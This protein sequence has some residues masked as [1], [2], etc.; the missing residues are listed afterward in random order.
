LFS[1]GPVGTP[2]A[3]VRT[4][5]RDRL[6]KAKRRHEDMKKKAVITF[7]VLV[8][9]GALA[10]TVFAWQQM[11]RCFDGFFGPGFCCQGD[12]SY[13]NLTE[14]QRAE[15]KELREEF[16]QDIAGLREQM[17]AKSEALRT[18]L[19]GADPDPEEAKA[20]QKEMSGLMADMAQHRIDF[21]LEAKKIAPE[22]TFRGWGR[23]FSRQG[24]GWAGWMG[25]CGGRCGGPCTDQMKESS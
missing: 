4:N 3:I 5:G 11:G 1:K 23:R 2:I 8:L 22:A 17:Q 6:R 19:D 16:H 12:G 14:E 10:V 24:P 13:G 15:M 18:L 9:I 20:L 25:K 7:G 21:I